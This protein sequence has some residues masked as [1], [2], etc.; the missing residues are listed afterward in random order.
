M[1][2]NIIDCKIIGQGVIRFEKKF[3][4]LFKESITIVLRTKI[5]LQN[6]HTTCYN[7]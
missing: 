3:Q 5:I 6:R 2:S 1:F 7:V 4:I